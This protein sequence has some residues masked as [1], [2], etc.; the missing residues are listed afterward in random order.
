MRAVGA[1]DPDLN[2]SEESDKYGDPDKQRCKADGKYAGP[3]Y[4]KSRHANQEEVGEVRRAEMAVDGI[5][6]GAFYTV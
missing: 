4:E 3:A 2:E 6:D 5:S 1:H